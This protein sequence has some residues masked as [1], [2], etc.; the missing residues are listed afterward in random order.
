MKAFTKVASV[1]SLFKQAVLGTEQNFTQG[2]INKALFLL[3][4]PMILE[5]GMESVFAVVD[6]FFVS[7]LNSKEAVAA[8]GTTELILTIIYSVAM[9]LGMGATAMVSRRIGES[10]QEGA[11][12]A[13]TQAI[14]IGLFSIV[15]FTIV[16]LFFYEDLLALLGASKEVI[17]IGSGYTQLMLGGNIV[18]VLLFLI[19]GIFRGAGNAAIAMRALILANLL[20]IVLDPLFIFGLGPVPAMGVKG[21]ALATTIGRGIGVLYQLYYLFNKKGIIKIRKDHFKPDWNIII[22]LL[23][24]SAGSTGQ[25]IISSASWIVLGAILNRFGSATF[26]GYTFAIRVMVFTLLPSFG[27]ANAAATLVGQNLGAGYP[28]RA[29]KS[30][31]QAGLMNMLFLSIVMVVF[32][33]FSSSII[34]VFTTDTEVIGYGSQALQIVALGYVFYGYGMVITQSFNGAGDTFTPTLLNFLGF[35]CFQI[36]LAYLLALKWK[37]GP[38]GVYAAISIAES[39]LAIAGILIFRRGKWKLVKI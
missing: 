11:T 2:S 7:M 34:G 31:W 33:L 25:F 15:V 22:S 38:V 16:G 24:L 10:N 39:A 30:V 4:V 3:S 14:Y 17:A 29:E 1:F 32:L 6:I 21:A 9:G 12:V 27:L 5:M 13:A 19:N 36:P 23:K 18:I 20:N 35:W 26:A 28:D 37:L 8:V